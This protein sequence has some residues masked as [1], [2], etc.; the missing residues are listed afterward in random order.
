MFRII[1]PYNSASVVVEYNGVEYILDNNKNSKTR[2]KWFL[3]TE[4]NR[5]IVE[6]DLQ[7]VLQ[8]HLTNNNQ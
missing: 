5:I 4:S 7:E 2:N 1:D 6:E 3:N 8:K